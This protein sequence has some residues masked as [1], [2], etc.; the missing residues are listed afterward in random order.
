[1]ET[2]PLFKAEEC[3]ELFSGS[4]RHVDQR[5]LRQAHPLKLALLKSESS[6]ATR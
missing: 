2:F 1:M 6:S 3:V 4:A 5:L